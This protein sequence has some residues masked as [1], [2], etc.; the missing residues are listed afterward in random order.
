M[1]PQILVRSLSIRINK[2]K[3]SILE[4]FLT[5]TQDTWTDGVISTGDHRGC[6]PAENTWYYPVL[7][8]C[9]YALPGSIFLNVKRNEVKVPWGA[10]MCRL[11]CSPLFGSDMNRITIHFQ[12]T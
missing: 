1:Y 2:K 6:K 5:F 8:I 3:S 9:V 4:L 10:L 7:A 11:Y 12:E